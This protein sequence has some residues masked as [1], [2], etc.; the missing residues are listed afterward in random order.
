MTPLTNN[1]ALLES[2]INAQW[3]SGYTH[4]N[5]GAAWG[6]RLISPGEPFTQGSAYGDPDWTKAVIILTDGENTTSDSVDTAYGYRWQGILGSTSGSGT[7]AELNSRLTEVCTA[8]T[9]KD[10]LVYTI[11]FNVSSTPTQAPFENCPTRLAKYF[12]SPDSTTL[13]QAFRAIGAELKSLHL[14]K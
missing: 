5:F 6:W 1:R 11:T 8:M 13:T 3:A 14:S 2:E 10:I 7:T 4:I 9:N 12:N